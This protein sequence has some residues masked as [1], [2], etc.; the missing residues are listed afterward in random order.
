MDQ[1]AL[2]QWWEQIAEEIE[3][4]SVADGWKPK[5][6]AAEE[7]QLAWAWYYE[8]E[9]TARLLEQRR[10]EEEAHHAPPEF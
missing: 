10:A 6:L 1:Q 4:D 7:A 8:Q 5:P 9:E 3:A 2:Q